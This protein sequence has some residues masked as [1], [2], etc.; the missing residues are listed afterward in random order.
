MPIFQIHAR[1]YNDRDEKF[2]F[3]YFL[4]LTVCLP[5][6]SFAVMSVNSKTTMQIN[7]I[8]YNRGLTAKTIDNKGIFIHRCTPVDKGLN[9]EYERHEIIGSIQHCSV[10]VLIWKAN[11]FYFFKKNNRTYFKQIKVLESRTFEV[12]K[13]EDQVVYLGRMVELEALDSRKNYSF[14]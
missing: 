2:I 9:F 13:I 1:W 7:S 11:H 3:I 14:L 12:V 5:K 4:A 10:N 6:V 8:D